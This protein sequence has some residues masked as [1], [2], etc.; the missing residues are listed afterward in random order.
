MI[1]ILILI[2][3]I[4]LVFKA[5][6]RIRFKVNPGDKTTNHLPMAI[7]NALSLN[8][9]ITTER[10]ER[11]KYI[12]NVCWDYYQRGKFLN[13]SSVDKVEFDKHYGKFLESARILTGLMDDDLKSP[14]EKLM[15]EIDIVYDNMIEEHLDIIPELK[16]RKRD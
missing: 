15:S 10:L 8:S 4:F 11:W 6:E 5:N 3:F 9:D 16:S 2:L 14:S 1:S 7:G 13:K 12:T